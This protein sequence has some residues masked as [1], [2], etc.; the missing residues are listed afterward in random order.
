MLTALDAVVKGDLTCKLDSVEKGIAHIKLS[1]TLEG[2]AVGSSTQVKVT[3]FYKYHLEGKYIKESDF[4]QTETRAVGPVSPGLDITARIRLLRQ[5]V[6]SP[7]RLNDPKVI[8][9][10]GAEP[11]ATAKFLRFESPWNIGLQHSRHWFNYKV[12]D[13]LAVFRLLLDGNF[14]AQCDM[15]GI[16]S[17]KPGEH[18]SEQIF[19]N[20]I[21]HSLGDRMRKLTPGE[22]VPSTDHKFVYKVV[23]EGVV[24]ERQVTWV[25]YLVADKTGRQASLMFTVDTEL[26][27]KLAPYDLEIVNSLKFGPA[28]VARSANK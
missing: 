13:K 10:A 25:F 21:Q 15:A 3:G 5:P 20:D 16:P 18:L 23:A 22:V 11:A 17:V 14:V 4:T 7:G 9:A 24:G 12:D 26:A 6:S 27:E 8:D 28:P 1:G 2:A 19:L